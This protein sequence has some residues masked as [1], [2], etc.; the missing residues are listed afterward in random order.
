MNAREGLTMA[1]VALDAVELIDKLVHA[2]GPAEAIVEGLKGLLVS[3]RDGVAGKTSPQ[4]V[5]S[6]LDS[7][8][9][10][11]AEQDAAADAELAGRFPK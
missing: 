3:L 7:L 1:G 11:L 10:K 9:H 8:Q 4:V 5:M 6:H 2:G